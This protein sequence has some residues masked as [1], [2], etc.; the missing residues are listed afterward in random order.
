[1]IYIS[2][3]VKICSMKL[4]CLLRATLLATSFA[5]EEEDSSRLLAT[6]L[7]ELSMSG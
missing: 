6:R 3:H 2:V 4:I 5:R 7:H 1:M